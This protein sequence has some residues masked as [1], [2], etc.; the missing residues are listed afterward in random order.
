MTRSAW[1]CF[2]KI[3]ASSEEALYGDRFG[4]RY[5][6]DSN[7]INSSRLSEGDVL[8][9]RDAQLIFGFGV[10]DRID[11]TEGEKEILRCP[12]CRKS[13]VVRRARLLPEFRC[14]KCKAE[15]HAPDL[16]IES[17]TKFVA[18]YSN[19]WLPLPSPAPVRLLADVYAGADQQ[20]AI[21]ELEPRAVEDLVGRLA[22]IDGRLLLQAT[23][24]VSAIEGGFLKA[25]AKAR[26]GQAEFRRELLKRYGAVCA[27]TGPQPEQ[28][29]DAAHLYAYAS[30]PHHDLQGGLLLRADV[31]RLFD[32][33]VLTIDPRTWR[34]RVDPALTDRFTLLQ[35]LSGRDLVLGT[36]SRP[37][38]DLIHGHFE[39]ATQAWRSRRRG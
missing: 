19:G 33:L 11:H 8:V 23:R 9:I 37:R 30:S 29:L 4:E 31:H 2:S 7:V 3:F 12:N 10:V 6:Y 18:R 14:S 15:F 20:N 21:R 38:I 39:L 1:S 16:G 26:R 17:V 35:E 28:V 36:A 25:L 32:R 27:V 5:E 24:E 22:G 34:A 13:A